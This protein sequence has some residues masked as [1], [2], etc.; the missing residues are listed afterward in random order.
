[1]TTKDKKKKQGPRGQ[2]RGLVE[3]VPSE[4]RVTGRANTLWQVVLA[5]AA[6]GLF[7]PGLMMGQQD[8]SEPPSL[9]IE[10]AVLPPTY[11]HGR[12]DVHFHATGNY[13][14]VLRWRVESGALPAGLR[15]AE[16]GTLH[17]EAEKPGE[18]QFAISARDGGQPQQAVQKGYVIKVLDAMT[19][20]W[21][22]LPHVSGNRISGDVEVSNA[23][24]DDIDLTF[25]VKAIAE[26]G[27]ATEIG[28]QHYV[29]TRGT[30]GMV[31]PFGETLPFG[32]YLVNVNLVG[33]VAQRNA[34]YKQQLQTPR[35]LRVAVGP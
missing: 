16:D 10:P 21:K 30:I 32:A 24:A 18:F 23:T 25:D 9:V 3:S 20:A 12:Y 13:V 34:I 28:Y 26:N 31:L 14:P 17:G 27:R 15:L 11:P 5:L 1:M 6:I 22:T 8:P 19:L 29:L 7:A 4:V 33:E 35:P 2:G